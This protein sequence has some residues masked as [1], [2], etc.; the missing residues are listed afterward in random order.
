MANSSEV[1][2]IVSELDAFGALRADLAARAGAAPSP[3]AR[4]VT[5]RQPPGD[6]AREDA[7]E[8]ARAEAW[9]ALVIGLERA[10]RLGPPKLPA[11]F[12]R[13]RAA[14]DA[15][16]DVFGEARYARIGARLAR[17]RAPASPTMPLVTELLWALEQPEAAGFARL[18]LVGTTALLGLVPTDDVRSGYVLAQSARA[19]RNLGDV[20][21]AVTRYLLSEELG[22]RHKNRRLQDRSALG[23]GTSYVFVGNYPASRAAWQRVLESTE[24]DA[25]FIAAA[26]H[27]LFDSA[28]TARDWGTAFE[29][30]WLLLQAEQTGAINR[31]EVLLN[32]SDLCY[33][34]GQ[35]DV[36]IRTAK[37]V[38]LLEPLRPNVRLTAT[39]TL[40]QIA[41]DCRNRELYER[42]V[43]MLQAQIGTVAGP[44]EDARA[45]LVLAE[46]EFTF[47]SK[48]LAS[49]H[50]DAARTL[51]NR[52]GY[53]KVQ[54][55][56]EQ[57]DDRFA[58][59]LEQT[60]R[61]TLDGNAPRRHS[62]DRRSLEIVAQIG[63][64]D[65][66]HLICIGG[67]CET[68]PHAAD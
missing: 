22:T 12:R 36:A 40:L 19:V 39:W 23:L 13:Q 45:L 6:A 62:L 9:L 41:I 42:Y 52:F 10:A 24:P 49:Q 47:G 11:H 58:A 50:L 68:L 67:G 5:V 4:P 25:E 1:E 27:G 14:W 8:A 46:A 55:D 32:I 35:Y 2:R 18:A 34:V 56:V 48:R 21:G 57:L 54:F 28:I 37:A 15:A 60:K 61:S 43:R 44:F 3:A 51:A 17:W 31:A 64:L 66:Q 30:G 26:R 7:A 63:A 38:L 33:C 29:Q 20:S 53:H 65:E 16:A 59:A